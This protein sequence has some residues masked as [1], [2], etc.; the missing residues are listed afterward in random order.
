VTGYSK[1][2]WETNTQK[3]SDL[4]G[5]LK[6]KDILIPP[7]TMIQHYCITAS[8]TKMQNYIALEMPVTRS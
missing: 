6:P 8:K 5:F 2:Y 3:W 7:I 1:K 4:F